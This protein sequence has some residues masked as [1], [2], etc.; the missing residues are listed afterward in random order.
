MTLNAFQMQFHS[1][2]GLRDASWIGYNCIKIC[3]KAMYF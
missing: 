2:G 1:T 3:V